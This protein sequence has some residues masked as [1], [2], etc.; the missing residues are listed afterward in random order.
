MKRE[1]REITSSFK[2]E[3]DL[4]ALKEK[5]TI[6]ELAQYY[7]LYLTQITT[8]KFEFLAKSSSVFDSDQSESLIDTHKKQ[9][10]EDDLNTQM[11]R[12]KNE[13]LNSQKKLLWYLWLIVKKWLTRMTLLEPLVINVNRS[14]TRS[15][16]YY[17]HHGISSADLAPMRVMEKINVFYPNTRHTSLKQGAESNWISNW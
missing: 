10:L 14:I 9:K 11:I 7:K 15:I 1:R 6:A 3:V 17:S 2:T 12:E 13:K 5:R 8:W 4:E 16:I